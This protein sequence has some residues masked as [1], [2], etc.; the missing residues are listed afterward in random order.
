MGYMSDLTKRK[1]YNEL[2][3]KLMNFSRSM[4]TSIKDPGNFTPGP[5]RV[6]LLLQLLCSNMKIKPEDFDK[7]LVQ[8]LTDIMTEHIRSYEEFKKEF[9]ENDQ[10]FYN[11][12]FAESILGS[13]EIW[14]NIIG[15]EDT[16]DTGLRDKPQ[17]IH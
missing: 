15:R 16:E 17:S 6:R 4:A 11:Q 3:D 13:D 1:N 5:A 12:L 7:D 8:Y 14:E 10:N 9:G 2:H